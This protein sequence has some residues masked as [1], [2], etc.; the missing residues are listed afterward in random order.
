MT[1]VV[2]GVRSEGS[3]HVSSF[4]LGLGV[5]PKLLSPFLTTPYS[6][7]ITVLDN[8][9]GLEWGVCKEDSESKYF[10]NKTNSTCQL[11]GC[12]P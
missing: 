4:D 11:I 7:R 3:D 10:N 5:T 8:Q 1:E 12:E 2:G 9:D 6:Q